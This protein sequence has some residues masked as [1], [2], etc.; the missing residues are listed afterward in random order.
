MHGGLRRCCLQELRRRGKD[1]TVDRCA[2]IQRRAERSGVE[3]VVAIAEHCHRVPSVHDELERPVETDNECVGILNVGRAR[4]GHCA[5]AIRP[6]RF[7]PL[8]GAK[9]AD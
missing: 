9:Y 3:A 7:V 4:I 1:S 8:E 2:G 5:T 6:R